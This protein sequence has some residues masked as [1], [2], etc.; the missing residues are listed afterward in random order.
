[1]LCKKLK[2]AGAWI[3]AASL[4][5]GSVPFSAIPVKAEELANVA[6]NAAATASDTET[7]DL[8]ADKVIDGNTTSRSSRWSSQYGDG[9]AWIQLHWDEAQTMKNIVIYWERRNVQ[10]Y[11]LEVSEDGE[12]WGE[13]I[14]SNS[15]YPSKN[16]ETIT[17]ENPVTAQY[18]RLY[19]GTINSKSVDASETEWKTAAIYEIE[20]FPDEIPDGRTEAQM[21]PTRFRLLRLLQKEIKSFLCRKIFR[22]DPMCAS[23]R[24]M[25]R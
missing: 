23:A 1:M 14:W 21:L 16:K 6:G 18:L 5:I 15:G 17:L 22:R 20:V 19:I 24:I 3:L 10:N 12:N 8:N 11:R 9:P 2:V 13:P 7:A 25:S 4:A